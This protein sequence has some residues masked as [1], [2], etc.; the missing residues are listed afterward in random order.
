M[1]VFAVCLPG[2]VATVTDR[3]EWL[4]TIQSAMGHY[5]DTGRVQ[6]VGG[7]CLAALLECC[8]EVKLQ[9]LQ[10][11][12]STRYSGSSRQVWCRLCAM[13]LITPCCSR[14]LLSALP[15]PSLSRT[16]SHPSPPLYDM[17]KIN[18]LIHQSDPEVY[19]AS[20]HALHN[21]ATG[22]TGRGE[23]KWEG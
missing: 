7:D 16:H 23:C 2:A 17:V 20:C 12:A 21:M 4:S 13:S 19:R 22:N 11:E 15:S 14:L 3:K 6:V 10:M 18:L 9:L 8:P 1:V 5:H